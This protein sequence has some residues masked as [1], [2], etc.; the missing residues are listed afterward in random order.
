MRVKGASKV[1]QADLGGNWKKEKAIKSLMA[2]D[3]K[4]LAA[5]Q[6]AQDGDKEKAVKDLRKLVDSAK[7]TRLDAV[8]RATLTRVQGM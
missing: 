5:V 4:R 6:K 7:G 3:K 8:M 2:L 1:W